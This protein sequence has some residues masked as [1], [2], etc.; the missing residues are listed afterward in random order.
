M[1]GLVQPRRGDAETW[2]LQSGRLVRGWISRP[3]GQALP[4][5]HGGGLSGGN[6]RSLS[7]QE[8]RATGRGENDI[9]VVRPLVTAVCKSNAGCC[10]HFGNDLG[11]LTYWE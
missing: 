11:Y 4:L 8:G 7:L 6:G 5:G 3:R 1:E 2:V 9:D 10:F